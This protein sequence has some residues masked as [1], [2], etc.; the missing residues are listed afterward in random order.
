MMID[1]YL[2]VDCYP[3]CVIV[4]TFECFTACAKNII[5]NS[6]CQEHNQQQCVP[7]T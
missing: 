5:N 4:H 7:R 1:H 6:V 2:A 3:I